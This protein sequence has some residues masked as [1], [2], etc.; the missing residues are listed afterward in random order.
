MI[1]QDHNYPEKYFIK[2]N[3][4]N[5]KF[6]DSRFTDREDNKNYGGKLDSDQTHGAE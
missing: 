1:R 6:G 4:I 5:S 3:D 2:Q